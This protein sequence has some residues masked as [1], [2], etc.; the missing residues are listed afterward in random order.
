MPEIKRPAPFEGT[1]VGRV[2]FEE[3]KI[4]FLEYLHTLRDHYENERNNYAEFTYCSRC[5]QY[6]AANLA[7]RSSSFASATL[8]RSTADANARA[9]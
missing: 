3:E 2:Y 7:A 1:A 6:L 5:P 9:F 8:L 4:N